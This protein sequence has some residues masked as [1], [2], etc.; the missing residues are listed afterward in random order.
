[1]SKQ[2]GDSITEEEGL[3]KQPRKGLVKEDKLLLLKTYYKTNVDSAEFKMLFD[4]KRNKIVFDVKGHVNRPGRFKRELENALRES[5]TQY[6]WMNKVVFDSYGGHLGYEMN[7]PMTGISFA[8]SG[9]KE[10]ELEKIRSKFA[11]DLSDYLSKSPR[12]ILKTSKKEILGNVVISM[13]GLAAAA[14]VPVVTFLAVDAYKQLGEIGSNVKA[15]INS[16]VEHVGEITSIKESLSDV[17]SSAQ[18]VYNAVA[19]VASESELIQGIHTNLSTY[20]AAIGTEIT[21]AKDEITS[22]ATEAGELL[23]ETGVYEQMQGYLDTAR[24]TLSSLSSGLVSTMASVQSVVNEADSAIT[25]VNAEISRLK[26][27]GVQF[28]WVGASPNNVSADADDDGVPDIS[29]DA[30]QGEYVYDMDSGN[31]LLDAHRIVNDPTHPLY[32][33]PLTTHPEYMNAANIAESYCKSYEVLLDN[34][35]SIE[36]IKSTAETVYSDLD[37][38]ATD[39]DSVYSN[40]VSVGGDGAEAENLL[41]DARAATGDIVTATG[42]AGTALANAETELANISTKLAELDT[43]RQDID[44]YLA[45]ISSNASATKTGADSAYASLGDVEAGLGAD[46][47]AISSGLAADESSIPG[48][49]ASYAGKVGDVVKGASLLAPVA[50]LTWLVNRRRRM[51]DKKKV[52]SL[53]LQGDFGKYKGKAGYLAA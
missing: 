36:N 21:N 38:A 31:E 47:S 42:N 23:G 49:L 11:E 3:L 50:Y 8:P 52:R 34:K 17:S 27:P 5:M 39:I 2:S 26:S 43:S 51:S 13:T 32:G 33:G 15:A 29:W 25:S 30:D 37:T 4:E 20:A 7:T 28:N 45:G 53:I 19:T 18:G 10:K 1:M 41:D 22:I 44:T 6:L 24:G 9:I 16:A 14:A 12:E 40:V 48:T 46:H 35:T